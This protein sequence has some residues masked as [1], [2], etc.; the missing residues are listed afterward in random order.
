MLGALVL[1]SCIEGEEEIWINP[2][3]SGRVRFQVSAPTVAFAKFGG[4]DQVITDAREGL[5]QSENVTLT[6][7]EAAATGTNTTLK[8]SFTF[9]D[10]REMGNILKSFRD[11]DTPDE[12]S[13]EEIFV[14]ETDLTIGIPD[15]SFSRK[16]DIR[17]LLPPEAQNPMALR[18]LGNSR[19]TY[20]MHLP[21]PVRTH[22]AS[23]V[24]KDGKSLA[25]EV[26]LQELLAGPVEMKFTAPLP[27]LVRYFSLVALALLAIIVSVFFLL[28]KRKKTP[29]NLTS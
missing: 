22:N 16:I 7:V 19:F 10:A 14:G 29:T 17:E 28:K 21:T 12:K 2:D 15:L 27:Y 5:L 11:P 18:L 4:V 8:A 9:K 6:S 25:W 24:S 1:S 3:A 26:P 20:R 13:E 23:S